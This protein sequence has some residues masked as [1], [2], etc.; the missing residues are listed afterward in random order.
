MIVCE[1]GVEQEEAMLSEP[2]CTWII[3][4]VNDMT[5]WVRRNTVSHGIRLCIALGQ[6][7][8]LITLNGHV[9]TKNPSVRLDLNIYRMY[10]DVKTLTSEDIGR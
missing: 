9:E 7:A 1:D 5:V 8:G 6:N 2:I 4:N 3:L 10:F